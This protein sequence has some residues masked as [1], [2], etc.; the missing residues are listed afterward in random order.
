MYQE[1]HT[2]ESLHESRVNELGFLSLF[3]LLVLKTSTRK[4]EKYY[5]GVKEVIR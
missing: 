4:L 1:Y 3:T 5:E 2:E